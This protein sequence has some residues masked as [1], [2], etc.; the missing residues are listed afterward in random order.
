VI[1]SA[2]ID[3]VLIRLDQP[4]DGTGFYTRPE[5]LQALNTAQRLACFFSLCLEATFPVSI[6][7]SAAVY[8][9]DGIAILRIAQASARVERVSL[10]SLAARDAKWY[11]AQENAVEAY[12][13]LSASKFAIYPRPFFGSSL[14]VTTARYPALMG[15]GSTPEIP[16]E[17]HQALA[18]GAASILAGIKE[19]GQEQTKAKQWLAAYVKAVADIADAVRNR[20]RRYRYDVEPPPLAVDKIIQELMPDGPKRNA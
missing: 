11:T 4:V 9:H 15:E 18:D 3:Q 19:G 14:N 5:A 13:P 16:D 7:S 20:S 12:A 1:A 6:D 17:H 2:I 8:T 10:G